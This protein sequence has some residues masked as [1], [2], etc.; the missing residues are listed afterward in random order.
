MAT[1]DK[2]R[3]QGDQ[4][5]YGLSQNIKKYSL[6][7]AGFSEKKSGKF[8]LERNLDPNVSPNVSLKLKIVVDKDLKKFKMSTTTAN[9]LKDVDIFKT[10]DVKAQNEQLHYL[11]NDLIDRGILRQ[12]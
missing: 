10:G 2:V 1:T 12:I 4:Q 7:D 6:R 11:L 3:I 9:G 5:T 8:Q